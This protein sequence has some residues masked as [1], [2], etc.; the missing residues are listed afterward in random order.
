MIPVYHLSITQRGQGMTDSDHE[1]FHPG[2]RELQQ[3]FDSTRLAN[4]LSGATMHDWITPRDK[5]FIEARDMF[6]LATGDADGNLD[7]S[8]KGGDPGF[9]RVIDEQ[10][11]AFPHYDGNGMFM[12]TGN[13]LEH[14]KVG[15]LFIDFENQWR[16]RINGEA[17]IEQR[18]PLMAEFREGSSWCSCGRT[19]SFPRP[20]YI[21]KMQLVERSKF[22]PKAAMRRR[23]RTGRTITTRSSPPRRSA[24]PGARSPR[25]AAG[26]PPVRQ[27]L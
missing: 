10:T 11:L 19:R 3:R 23:S 14:P 20:R 24:G 15:M 2:E 17:W 12:S 9:V 6:F 22:V 7:C 18:P 4:A 16:M 21:H 1:V 26:H 13:I 5:A 25:E 27:A 8:Y